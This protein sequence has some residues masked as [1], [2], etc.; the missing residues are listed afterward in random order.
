MKWGDTSQVVTA[1]G[2]HVLTG[3][4][5]F[6]TSVF[7]TSPLGFVSRPIY[8]TRVKSLRKNIERVHMERLKV[9]N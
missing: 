6:Q 1:T 2:S 3:P 5:I 4:C 9:P 8:I 7:N